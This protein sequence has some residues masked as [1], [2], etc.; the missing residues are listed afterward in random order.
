MLSK[1]SRCRKFL[2]GVAGVA[3]QAVQMGLVPEQYRPWGAVV[4]ATAVA[5]G[6]YVTPNATT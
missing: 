4:L 3:V 6:I 2:V 5:L 1:L